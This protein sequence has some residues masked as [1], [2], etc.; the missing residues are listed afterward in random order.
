MSLNQHDLVDALRPHIHNFI[1]NGPSNENNNAT[2]AGNVLNSLASEC[3]GGKAVDDALAAQG[4]ADNAT[5]NEDQDPTADDG[6]T[7][8]VDDGS[9]ETSNDTSEEQQ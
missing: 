4:A 2:E 5:R 3:F 7:A 6:A 8:P 1:L 9:S